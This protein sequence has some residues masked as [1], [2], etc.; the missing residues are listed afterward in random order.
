MFGTKVVEE[1]KTHILCSITSFFF[2]NRAIYEIMWKNT[3]Q[4]DTQQMTIWR[5]RTACLITKA[6]RTNTYCFTTATMV[7][8]PHLNVTSHIHCL[9]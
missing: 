9:S 7:A 8:G 1:I 2:E 5:M 4:L 6:T 3:V